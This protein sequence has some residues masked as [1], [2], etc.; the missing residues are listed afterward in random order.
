MLSASWMTENSSASSLFYPSPPP[1]T[2]IEMIQCCVPC[3]GDE[4]CSKYEVGVQVVGQHERDGYALT[5]PGKS[6]QDQE[7]TRRPWES[8]ASPY[9]RRQTT[10]EIR[11]DL[12]PHSSGIAYSALRIDEP[13]YS[14]LNTARES[15]F[16]PDPVYPR[17]PIRREV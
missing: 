12:I 9:L 6:A 5:Q 7:R 8:L 3:S 4:H 16:D 10:R 17:R 1:W 11:L 13:I 15:K 2:K 14:I